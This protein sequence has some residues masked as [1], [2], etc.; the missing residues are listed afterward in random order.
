MFNHPNERVQ[1]VVPLR[2]IGRG[3]NIGERRTC[4]VLTEKEDPFDNFFAG[5]PVR[6]GL[7]VRIL[8][9]SVPIFSGVAITSGLFEE[10]R[11]VLM[12]VGFGLSW[13]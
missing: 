10:T 1:D 9:L 6:W 13:A 2:G 11:K 12:P 3:L 5:S 8:S 7:F 4:L